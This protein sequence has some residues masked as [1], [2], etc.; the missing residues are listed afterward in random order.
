MANNVPNNAEDGDPCIYE[1]QKGPKRVFRAAIAA[2]ILFA[3]TV[4]YLVLESFVFEWRYRW[5]LY[6]LVF[7]WSV[8]PPFWFW[9]EY[10]FNFKPFGRHSNPKAFDHLKHGQQTAA[11]IWAGVLAFIILVA[12]TTQKSQPWDSK[13]RSGIDSL[14]NAI[15]DKL[16]DVPTTEKQLVDQLRVNEEIV[17]AHLEYLRRSNKVKVD[18]DSW[19]LPSTK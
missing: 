10:F 13:A 11:A 9:F 12:A 7:A 19:R 16:E 5:V 18:G 4:I 2:F 1:D 3:V 14:H 17:H 6:C 8:L 15:L